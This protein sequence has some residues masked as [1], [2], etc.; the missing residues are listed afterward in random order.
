MQRTWVT[1]AVAIAL[2]AFCLIWL[3]LYCQ[4]NVDIRVR[5]VL[6]LPEASALGYEQA[7]DRAHPK[8]VAM[9]RPAVRS[10]IR[11]LKY[12]EGEDPRWARLLAKTPF[13]GRNILDW[14]QGPEPWVRQR[15]ALWLGYLGPL[16]KP[17]IPALLNAVQSDSSPIVRHTIVESLIAIGDSRAKVRST[18]ERLA[19][20]PTTIGKTLDSTTSMRAAV[21]HWTLFGQSP[22]MERRVRK[23]ILG[24]D[25]L[26]AIHAV[27]LAGER[28]T[29][30]SNATE[31]R[32]DRIPSPEERITALIQAG[33]ILSL[34]DKENALE[35]LAKH[36]IAA[37]RTRALVRR[38]NTLKD[39]PKLLEAYGDEPELKPQIDEIKKLAIQLMPSNSTAV[40]P[41]PSQEGDSTFP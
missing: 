23:A 32:I 36:L 33:S 38:P 5:K 39:L 35:R 25:P 17:A 4:N 30:F 21:A 1:R 3:R 24:N 41:K 2:G 26:E 10:L 15:A 13:I 20:R 8:L 40:R 14:V 37:D 19:E 28:A 12:V 16:A 7:R 22:E 31:R 18:L 9:G 6:D 27:Q 11:E 29:V 34:K